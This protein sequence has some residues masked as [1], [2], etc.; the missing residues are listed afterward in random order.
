MRR[1]RG[2]LT[3][4]KTVAAKFSLVKADRRGMGHV[5]EWGSYPG[6]RAALS[7]D[8]LAAPSNRGVPSAPALVAAGPGR[9]LGASRTGSARGLFRGPQAPCSDLSLSNP[10]NRRRRHDAARRDLL[11]TQDH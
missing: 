2:P 3:F 8:R 9:A 11:S 7:G 10:N 1:E 4:S 6:K 5:D